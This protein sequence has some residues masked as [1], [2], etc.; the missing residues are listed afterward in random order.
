[1]GIC[2]LPGNRFYIRS[3]PA[4]TCRTSKH[5]MGTGNVG[6]RRAG[7]QQNVAPGTHVIAIA[8]ADMAWRDC[9]PVW[10]PDRHQLYHGNVGRT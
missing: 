7:T 5:Y 1:M 6:E 9:W 8:L 3:T 2:W 10:W 4:S